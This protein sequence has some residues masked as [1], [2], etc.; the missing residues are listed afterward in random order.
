MNKFHVSSDDE[1]FV[2]R[3]AESYVMGLCWVMGYYYQA[4][5][6]LL[7]LLYHSSPTNTQGCPSWKWYYPF[8]YAPFASDFRHIADLNNS[9]VGKTEPV[10]YRTL[11][12]TTII[13]VLY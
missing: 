1:D 5:S 7:F 2:A 12:S 4:S 6:G 11:S 3:V 9:F 8:H 10:G 13:T